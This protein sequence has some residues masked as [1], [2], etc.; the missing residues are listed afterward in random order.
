MAQCSPAGVGVFLLAGIIVTVWIY[1]KVIVET[2]VIATC[3]IFALAFLFG[4]T[5]L[6]MLY[7][8]WHRAKPREIPA[9]VVAVGAAPASV[10]AKVK[11]ADAITA[12]ADWLSEDAVELAF[13]PDGK[14]LKAKVK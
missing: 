2:L 11:D 12:E 4:M 3:T 7:V 9:T 14:T 8:R 1:H 5:K 13:S 6:A 10:P